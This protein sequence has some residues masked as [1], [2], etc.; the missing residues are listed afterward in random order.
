MSTVVSL[1]VK[2]GKIEKLSPAWA[3]VRQY[4]KKQTKKRE[5]ER[6]KEEVLGNKKGGKGRKEAERIHPP[7]LAGYSYLLLLKRWKTSPNP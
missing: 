2:T 6:G 1:K 5:R 4:L 3:S 7:T